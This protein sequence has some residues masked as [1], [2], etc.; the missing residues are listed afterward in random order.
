MKLFSRKPKTDPA[1]ARDPAALAELLELGDADEEINYASYAEQL[2]E[3]T[4]DL[5]RMVLDEDFADR[6][7]DDPAA[8]RPSTRWRCWRSWGWRRLP[9]HCWP[10]WNGILT[11]PITNGACLCGHRP[12]RR[13]PAAGLPGRWDA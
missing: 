5:I 8:W 11:G 3:Y 12:G 9:N 1:L 4:P 13:A 2:G 10:V 6:E 7:K